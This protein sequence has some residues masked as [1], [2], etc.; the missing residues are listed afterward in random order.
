MTR[1]REKKA[2]YEIKNVLMTFSLLQHHSG[3]GF[4]LQS[5]DLILLFEVFVCLACQ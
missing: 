4:S 3:V 5:K 2:P 1:D